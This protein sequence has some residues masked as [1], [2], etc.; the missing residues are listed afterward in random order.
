[1]P[2]YICAGCVVVN[3]GLCRHALCYN[4]PLWYSILQGS[5]LGANFAALISIVQ[6]VYS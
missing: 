2:L 5:C 4:V 1:M 6:K 3:L